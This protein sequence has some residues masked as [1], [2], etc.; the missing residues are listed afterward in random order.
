MV[1]NASAV[2]FGALALLAGTPTFATSARP[3]VADFVQ[4][5]WQASE[6]T[7]PHPGVTSFL[8]TRDGYLWIGTYA[9]VTRFDGVQF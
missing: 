2:A 4:D 6:R 9:G 1:D 5:V 7:L 3:A 8:Q